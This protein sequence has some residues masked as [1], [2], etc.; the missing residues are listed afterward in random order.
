[1]LCELSQTE[2][3]HKLDNLGSAVFISLDII[4]ELAMEELMYLG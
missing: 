3:K 4:E 2:F 1:M